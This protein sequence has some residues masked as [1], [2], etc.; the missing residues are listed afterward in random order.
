[1][2]MPYLSH[3]LT[4]DNDVE[5]ELLKDKWKGDV[6]ITRAL[7]E[8]D[9][10]EAPLS[11][12]LTRADKEEIDEQWMAELN[13]FYNTCAGWDRVRSFL[14]DQKATNGP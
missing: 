12:H 7:F 13:R 10:P 3:S 9:N 1:M 14:T 4:H 5:L 6:T 8:H 2:A 11:W